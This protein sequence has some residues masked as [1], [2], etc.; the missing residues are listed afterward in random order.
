MSSEVWVLVEQR[1][2]KIDE[3]SCFGLLGEAQ[4]LVSKMKDGEPKIP[5]ITA[6]ALGKNLEGDL[7]SLGRYGAD[8]VLYMEHDEFESYH[9]DLYA[10]VLSQAIENHRPLCFLMADS[11]NVADLAPRLAALLDCPLATLCVDIEIASDGDLVVTRPLACGKLY[12]KIRFLDQKTRLITVA[13]SILESPDAAP[14]CKVEIIREEYKYDKKSFVARSV[15]I[16][17]ADPD[18]V[19]LDDADIIVAGGKGVGKDKFDEIIH[20]L[21]KAMSAS[22][23][24]SRPV[25]DWG[26]L[27]YE[28]QIGQTGKTVRPR[29]IVTCGIS[30]ANEFTAGIEKSKLVVAI[31]SDRKARIFDYADLGIVGDLHQVIPALVQRLN[32]IKESE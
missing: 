7:V 9:G 11:P 17:K 29:L 18:V 8:R 3:E 5:Q 28:R 32:E 6:I 23:A 27:P 21:A 24:G 13:P 15:E 31:N 19:S 1:E 30:G 4:R 22:L 16:I 20:P 26:K 10:D 25:V 14:L 12:G 2:S